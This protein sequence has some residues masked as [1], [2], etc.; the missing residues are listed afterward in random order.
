MYVFSNLWIYI[1]VKNQHEIANSEFFNKIGD[2][3]RLTWCPAWGTYR[4][5]NE[6]CYHI[7][8]YYFNNI[9]IFWVLLEV[10]M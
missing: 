1:S 6:T 10:K 7:Q 4:V 2:S 3:G 9:N 8:K 5:A